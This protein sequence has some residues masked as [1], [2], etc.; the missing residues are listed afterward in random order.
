MIRKMI[1]R[2]KNS[3]L[4]KQTWNVESETA[5]DMT[6]LLVLKLIANLVTWPLPFTLWYPL[7]ANEV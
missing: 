4:R 1:F 7:N 5:E 6:W 2:D 3:N